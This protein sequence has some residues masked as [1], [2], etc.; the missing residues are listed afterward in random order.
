M[1][2]KSRKRLLNA[3]MV[4]AVGVIILCGV[5]ITGNLKGW[6]RSS[7]ES[8]ISSGEVSG[9]CNIERQGI[10]YTL[11]KDMALQTA[12]IVE[13]EKGSKA[14][15][16]LFKA[17][18]SIMNAE[19]EMKIE[20]ASADKLYLEITRGEVFFD[21]SGP[22]KEFVI[23]F[24]ENTATVK[25][26]V[27]SISVQQGSSA[28]SV[29]DGSVDVKAEDESDNTVEKGKFISVAQSGGGKLFVGVSDLQINSLNAFMISC[30]TES[31][32]DDLC[33]GKEALAKL[34]EERQ[35]ER[36]RSA[37]SAVKIDK[38]DNPADSQTKESGDQADSDGSQGSGSEST[39][40][41]NSNS[42]SNDGHSSEPAG[43]N[44]GKPAANDKSCTITILCNTILDN[45]GNLTPGKEQFVPSNG[46]ILGTSQV[47][48][49]DGETVFD[50]LTRVCANT[51]IQIE[52]SWTPMY[53]SY[54]IEG[55]NNL[56]EFDCGHESGWMY[57]VNGWF[58]NYG[59]SSYKLADNDD[60]V[61]C[62]TC[63]G[64]GA[65]VGGS[66]Y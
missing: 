41:S 30:L 15:L 63:N 32:N 51:G 16:S 52:Y 37:E 39:S 8:F 38:K 4:I 21:V 24:G 7:A 22:P 2:T 50:V 40:I 35:A 19:A 18:K 29:F 42:N 54:Y 31:E 20:E 26:T 17:G 33:F 48:F 53:G 61:W 23:K 10:G 46:V 11:K 36:I 34:E 3:L 64:L 43:E 9:I 62:Y 12:D 28:L 5:M 49:S 45:M 44:A 60:I 55:I 6:F 27:F 59:C 66:V 47:S 57:K 56:Y 14:A 1:E 13:T 25:G 65:D 58:P